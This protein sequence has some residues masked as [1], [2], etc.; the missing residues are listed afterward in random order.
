MYKI[1]AAFSVLIILSMGIRAEAQPNNSSNKNQSDLE[2]QKAIKE[3]LT[4][5]SKAARA[6]VASKKSQAGSE[7]KNENYEPDIM[8]GYISKPEVGETGLLNAYYD[9]ESIDSITFHGFKILQIIDANNVLGLLNIGDGKGK[10]EIIWLK[11]STEGM[12]DDR[13]YRTGD[14]YF[15]VI[16]TKQYET[17][18][19]QKTVI[20]LKPVNK[21]TSK[22]PDEKSTN[23]KDSNTEKSFNSNKSTNK[24]TQW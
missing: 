2:K 9:G 1:I 3:A 16:G 5:K 10:N 12:V 22:K 19:G 23:K 4:A 24:S 6:K 20:V 13:I 8:L 17:L 11:I 15:E 21:P 7:K 18:L 14:Q